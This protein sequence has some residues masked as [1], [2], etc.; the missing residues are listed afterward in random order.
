MFV[1]VLDLIIPGKP[2]AIT[3]GE[4]DIT[5]ISASLNLP[6]PSTRTRTCT[7]FCR[8]HYIQYLNDAR[9]LTKCMRRDVRFGMYMLVRELLVH[10]Y[11]LDEYK[12]DGFT[13]TGENHESL[14]SHW[15]HVYYSIYSVL[16]LV[17]RHVHTSIS[18]EIKLTQRPRLATGRGRGNEANL[19]VDSKSWAVE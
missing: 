19:R 15:Y 12:F 8:L 7:Y 18:S 5:L 16:V 10:T 2:V 9:S 1:Y 3:W 6:L 11:D 17:L 4:R 14:S 13:I